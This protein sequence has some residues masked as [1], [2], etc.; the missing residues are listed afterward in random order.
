MSVLNE[1]LLDSALNWLIIATNALYTAIDQ[2]SQ[3]VLVSV[4]NIISFSINYF[5]PFLNEALPMLDH[6]AP[7]IGYGYTVPFITCVFRCQNL[8]K[9]SDFQTNFAS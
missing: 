8:Q 3:L 6:V 5:F 9:L 1:D 2:F 4:L 7:A